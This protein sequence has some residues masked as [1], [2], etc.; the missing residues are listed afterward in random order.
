MIEVCTVFA[1]RPDHEKWRDDYLMLLELQKRTAE[2]FGHRHTVV[3]DGVL[4]GFETIT[5]VLPDSLMKALLAGIIHRL[6]LPVDSHIV[7]VDADCLVARTLDDAFTE[8][9]P[10]DLMVTR[11]LHDTAPVNN[12]AMYVHRDG[13]I[14]A[15]HFFFAAYHRCQDHWGGDQEAISEVCAPVPIDNR[16]EMRAGARVAFVSMLRHAAVPKR[17]GVY[18]H[19]NPFIVHFKGE[20]KPWAKTYAAKFILAKEAA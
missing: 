4:P 17:K 14:A 1:P 2:H 15:Q 12:G 20:T 11:R 9:D 3:T 13:A 19:A 18:H 16:I 10:F 6:S 8:G 5:T 7:F